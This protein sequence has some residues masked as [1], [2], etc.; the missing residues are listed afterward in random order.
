MYSVHPGVVLEQEAIEHSVVLVWLAA[1][2]RFDLQAVRARDQPGH[3]LQLVLTWQLDQVAAGLRRLITDAEAVK[4][5]GQCGSGICCHAS[6]AAAASAVTVAYSC[7]SA[8]TV[9]DQPNLEAC[10][11]APCASL[12]RL[13]GAEIRSRTAAE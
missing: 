4:R 3:R 5:R 8:S 1:E 10:S 2:E 11:R 12:A 6:T 9:A 13:A 7:I